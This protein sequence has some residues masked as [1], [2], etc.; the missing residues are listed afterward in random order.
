[1]NASTAT[2]VSGVGVELSQ[3]VVDLHYAVDDVR[4][5]HQVGRLD[6]GVL[7]VRLHD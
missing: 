6:L 7:P 3:E 2:S 4:A 1:M 5:D